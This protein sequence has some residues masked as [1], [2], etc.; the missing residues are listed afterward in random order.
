M[1][2]ADPGRRR[3]VLDEVQGILAREAPP[4]DRDLL[5]SLSPVVY[6]D[7]PDAMALGLSPEAVAARIREYFQFVVRTM[8]P[9]HQLYRGLPGIH[10]VARSL[11]E[12]EVQATGSTH[13]GQYEISVI[14]THTPDAPFIFE[15][16]KNFF[17]RE[18]LRVFSAIHSIFSV[19]RQWERITSIGGPGED[20]SKELLC[21]FRVE[22]IEQKDRM[23]RVEHQI[24]S[25]LRSVFL[26]VEDFG[27]MTRSLREQKG[28]LRDR[29]GRPGG[30][31]AAR[32]FLDWLVDE[33]YVLMGILRFRRGPD[34]FEPDYDTALGALREPELLNVVFPG[35]MDEEQ[36]HLAIQDH[37]DRII[38]IDFRNNASAIHH[39][40]PVDDIVVRE[41]G[42]DGRLEAA[43]L[44]LGRLAKSAFTAKAES[45]PLLREKL[46]WLLENCGEAKNSH[47]YRATRAF[48]NHLPK[49]ELFYSDAASLKGI[50][51]QMIHIS[52]DDEIVTAVRQGPSYS[53]VRIAFSQGRWSSK[54]GIDLRDALA[55]QFGPVSFSSTADCGATT[56]VVHYFDAGSLEHPL[57]ADRIRALTA[58]VISTWE[59]QVARE[60]EHACGALEGRR[61]YKRYVRQESRSGLYRELTP[62]AE[63]PGDVRLFELIEGRLELGLVPD[64]AERVVLKVI[65][66]QPADLTE[67]LRTIRNLGPTVVEEMRIPLV[68]PEGKR[69]WMERLRIEADPAMVS[70]IHAQPDRFRDA[71]RAIYEERATDDPL[72]ALVLKEGLGWR[73]VEVLRTL[74]NHLLQVRPNYNGETVT[75]VLV[76]NSPV[77]G[78]LWRLFEARFDPRRE[79]G[80]AEATARAE[81]LVEKAF[82]AVGSLVDDEVL[83]GVASLLHAAVRTNYYQCPERPVLSIKVEC[84][85]V[86]GM[87]SPRPLF[88]IYVHSR[89][90]E[91]IH[92]RGGKVARG[93]IRWSD[94]HDDFRTEVLGLMKTQMVK[95]SVIVPVGSKGGFVLKGD[96][97]PRPALDAYLIDR[98][99]EFVSGLLDVTDNL[100]DGEVIHPPEVVRHDEPDPYL[101]VAADKGTAHLS[102]TANRVS[103]Q[104][105]F[106]LGDAFAS[107]GSNGYDHKKEGITA[108]GAWECVR[109]HFRSLGVDVQSEPFTMAGIGDMSG[110][111]FGNGVLLSRQTRLVAAFNHVHI[112]LDPNPDPV[113]S[114][115]ERERLFHLPRS[116][117][118]DYRPDLISAGGGIFDRGAKSIPLSPEVRGLLDLSQESA[119]GEDV[120]R[121]IL[122]APVD[123][124]YNGGI[125]TYVKAT[126]EED[127]E[128]GD[129]TNDRVRVTASEVRARVLAEGGNLG[130]TQRGRIELWTKGVLLNTDAVDNSGGVDMSDHEV[131]IKILLDLLVRRGIV[132][133]RADRNRIL[134]EMTDEVSRLVLADNANQA[135]ALTLDGLRS[136]RRHEEFVAFVEDLVATGVLRRG[137]DAVPP[138]D[139][140]LASPARDRGLPRPLLCVMLGHVKN[141]L[142]ASLLASP[143]PDSEVAQQFLPAY[144]PTRMRETY[145]DSLGLHPLRR[146]I[147]ATAVVNHVV[148]EGGVSLLHRLMTASGR[149]IGDVV[150]A[151]LAVE[152]AARADEV[153][154]GIEGAGL[155]VA[156]GHRR[157][158]DVSEALEEATR[159]VLAGDGGDPEKALD[160]VREGLGPTR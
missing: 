19:R 122:R 119:S 99:R 157:L 123:L 31:A 22:K 126:G 58:G 43:T 73:E 14:E 2:T 149:E 50:I 148:N 103:T 92:L 134:S 48:Y 135:L 36:K 26:A 54:T 85:R 18:G 69:A 5:L 29:R 113:A 3:S 156:D 35:V 55:R 24:H 81:A 90:L 118:R 49:R 70:A 109:H 141:R 159:H 56:L 1:I 71:L 42:A 104:Y 111:V 62:P 133:G 51:D 37:D 74:R 78:A 75:A 147:V 72:N 27:E 79:G 143:L 45:I 46:A 16:L 10:V 116:T 67:T 97:P 94:R 89:L 4:E 33:N 151:Y 142:Y 152:R 102:D 158:V 84:A 34:G 64:S 105:G 65:S 47:V 155:P 44:L 63:V 131:N 77:A 41:W 93:G 9:A 91:G 138:R 28:R 137:D 110:D 52:S 60:L 80:R 96:V 112:F 8:P 114:F 83:R 101:V 160:G 40:E 130:L 127:S 120:V 146:E 145:A 132:P 86:E 12:A 11:T 128:V 88:E 23:R 150:H 117:W 7:M 25:L 87:V 136:A 17:M 61:L 32:E 76:R 121:A 107:G 125:G 154:R 140:L 129:R 53:S 124:L 20:G 59:D 15:S 21:H 66:P 57:E 38:D 39:L 30:E 82:A 144:F 98:Y 6:A 106:W 68:L 13:G 139:E 108:R 100:V 95:N 153:R 115:A